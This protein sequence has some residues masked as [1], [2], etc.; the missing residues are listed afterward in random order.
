MVHLVAAG[1]FRLSFLHEEKLSQMH[2]GMWLSLSYMK[3]G[4]A[5]APSAKVVKQV[6]VSDALDIDPRIVCPQTC[7]DCFI[8]SRR[9][10]DCL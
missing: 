5:Q 7:A 4:T 9:E 8:E 6:P 2:K 3:R 1:S 10:E